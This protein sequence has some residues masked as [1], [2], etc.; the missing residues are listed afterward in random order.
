MKKKS[1]FKTVFSTVA[2]L[3]WLNQA[4]FIKGSSAVK[5]TVGV[6]DVTLFTALSN[7]EFEQL[8]KKLFVWRGYTVVDDN[9]NNID[10]ALQKDSQ[11]TFVQFYQWQQ[12]S[13]DVSSVEYLFSAMESY[14]VKNGII[15]ST[16]V[17][18]E[19]AIEF[20]LGKKILLVNG[21]DLSQMVEALMLSE[22]TSS[23]GEDSHD[24]VLENESDDEAIE[25]E[26]LCPLCSHKMIKRVAK[27][28]KNAGNTFWGCSQFPKCRGVSHK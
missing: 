20:S 25:T 23:E 1:L 14:E 13:V 22:S 16:G 11:I 17:F 27:K 21:K 9:E 26:P 7:K 19:E 18:T 28:G 6:V 4:P 24:S 8:I 2:K 15:M 10:L 5:N 3:P 12:N